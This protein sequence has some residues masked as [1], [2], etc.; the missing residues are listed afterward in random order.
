MVQHWYLVRKRWYITL[1]FGDKFIWF[2]SKVQC[3]SGLK[4]QR[5]ETK[6][7][8]R[9][10]TEQLKFAA[11]YTSTIIVCIHINNEQHMNFITNILNN[12]IMLLSKW[13][14]QLTFFAFWFVICFF[15]CNFWSNIM[16]LHVIF[17]II[18]ININID[19]KFMY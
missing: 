5:K 1:C 8:V 19:I 2:A 14:N 3:C 12:C 9:P 6:Q 17:L 4:H 7:R 11:N 18:I 15:I 13:D 10:A 16:Q